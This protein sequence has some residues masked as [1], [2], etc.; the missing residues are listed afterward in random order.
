MKSPH[1]F[2]LLLLAVLVA[3]TPAAEKSNE[4]KR[5]DTEVAESNAT[6]LSD[7]EI[8]DGWQ[9]LF[10][11]ISTD[12]WHSYLKEDVEGWT[13][14]YGELI[15]EGGHGDLITDAEFG[16]FELTLDFR[17]SPEGNS[18]IIYHVIEDVQYPATYMTGPEYQ[19]IDD[20]GWS[21][22][23]TDKQLTGANYDVHPP[24]VSNA[25]P[26]GTYNQ[27]RILVNGSHVEHW[28]NGEKVVEYERWTPEWEEKV[29]NSKWKNVP[30][31]G[32][33]KSGKIALQDHGNGTTTFR[34]IKIRPL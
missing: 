20:K 13:V 30:S 3:C 6:Q 18:G 7:A 16:N 33:A 22:E 29:A 5:A 9:L 17:I 1:T 21:G 34:N 2:L 24:L 14:K 25:S 12:G 10:D 19:L 4:G 27:A 31:Y 15:S 28:L 26:P 32:R 11:G 8:A 23:L